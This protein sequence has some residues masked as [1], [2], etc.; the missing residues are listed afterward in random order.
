M[1]DLS[2]G[3]IE[4]LQHHRVS[5][6]ELKM[7]NRQYYQ[8]HDLVFAREWGHLTRGKDSLGAPLQM[9]NL[10]QREFAKLIAAAKVPVIRFHDM[11]AIPA[12][13]YCWLP[14]FPCRLSVR[15]WAMPEWKPR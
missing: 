6:A 8:E 2:P 10:G 5:Q 7:K 3:T 1:I 13:R 15:D 12:P 9:N 11:R 4:R 14:A